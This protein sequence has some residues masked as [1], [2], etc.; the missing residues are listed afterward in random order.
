MLPATRVLLGGQAI[1]FPS[2]WT[3]KNAPIKI[4]RYGKRIKTNLDVASLKITGAGKTYYV[5]TTGVNTNDGL[6]PATALRDIDEAIAKADAQTIY[7][8]AGLYTRAL[9]TSSQTYANKKF[10]VIG[11]GGSVIITTHDVLTYALTEGQAHTYESARTLVGSVMD[12]AT[13]DAYG[14][15]T[16]LVLRESIA[17]VEANPGS[18]YHDGAKVYVHT[19]DSR[20]PDGNNRFPDIWACLIV[21]NISITGNSE[22]YLENLSFYGGSVLK[23]DS[24]AITD[25]PKVYGKNC[26]FM[27][28]DSVTPFNGVNVNG[29]ALCIF[30]NCVAAGNGYDG[31]NYHTQHSIIPYA[32]EINCVGRGNGDGSADNGSTMHDGGK[33]IRINGEYHDNSGPNMIDVN[34]G[35]ES[36]NLGCTAYHK[37]TPLSTNNFAVGQA[38]GAAKMWLDS[39]FAYSG[40]IRVGA[41][42]TLYTRNNIL[43]DD[44]SAVDGTVISY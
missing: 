7:V 6:S 26:K 14:E 23:L 39:C 27:N 40:D 13:K 35:T 37:I 31:F 43:S 44:L 36:W 20:S 38:T 42:S 2:G 22:V 8:K 25:T 18:W 17:D 4:Q 16:L 29:G 19:H 30:Q 32:I 24:A 15:P 21:N 33:I 34:A 1:P 11:Y 9:G 41:E 3:W 5:A 10:N 12:N 28:A